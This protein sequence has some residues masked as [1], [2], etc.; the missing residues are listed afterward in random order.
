MMDRKW[1]PLSR[2]MLIDNYQWVVHAFKAPLQKAIETAARF[3]I[4]KCGPIDLEH[5]HSINAR[6]LVILRDEWIKH[7]E[8][9]SKKVMIL[10]GFN[11]I[12]AE[13]E[14]DPFYGERFTWLVL[15]LAKIVALGKLEVTN[16]GVPTQYWKQ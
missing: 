7:E 13:I 1:S 12:I 6:H 8:N 9:D 2:E 10:A 14:H 4:E 3:L 11:I 15:A 5:V 16:N